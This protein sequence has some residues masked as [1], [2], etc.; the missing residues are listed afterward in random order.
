MSA[1][2]GE[3]KHDRFGVRVSFCGRYWGKADMGWRIAHI[4]F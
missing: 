3:G 2:W 4:C 1:L